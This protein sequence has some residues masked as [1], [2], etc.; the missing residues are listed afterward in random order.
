[1]SIDQIL[2]AVI[3]GVALYYGVR[4]LLTKRAGF[5]NRRSRTDFWIH[6]W[7]AVLIGL[8]SVLISALC[9]ASAFGMSPL[10]WAG[11]V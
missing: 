4:A 9:F 8:I 1:M 5:F 11:H 10:F 3:G 6:G 2:S 7:R